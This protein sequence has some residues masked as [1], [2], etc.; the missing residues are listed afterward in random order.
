MTPRELAPESASIPVEV[1]LRALARVREGLVLGGL[2]VLIAALS[3]ATRHMGEYSDEMFHVPQIQGFCHA[4]FSLDSAITMLPGFHAVLALAGS[5]LHDCS[6]PTL[7]TLN[8]ALLVAVCFVALRILITLHSRVAIPRALALCFLPLLFPY[9]FVVYTDVLGLLVALWALLLWLQHRHVTAGLVASV[10]VL[11]RQTNIAM[12]LLFVALA[13]LERDRHLGLIAQARALLRTCWSS[14]LG[15]AAF[16]AFVLYNGGIAV[17]DQSRHAL[18]VQVGNLYFAL[19]LV[20]LTA[21]APGL[22]E[23]WR[24]RTALRSWLFA[25]TLVA[26]Y[27]VYRHYFK[28]EHEYNHQHHFLHNELLMRVARHKR[29]LNL[30]FAPIALGL[31]IMWT[32]SWSRAAFRVWL[33]LA[34]AMMVPES[35]IEPRYALLP[36]ALFM[37][38]RKDSSPSAERLGAALNAAMSVTLVLMMARADLLL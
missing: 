34:A 27:L 2:A 29:T 14:A 17:G 13:W 31:A 4:D 35:L 5:A 18:G 37:L 26:S 15:L 7:R 12:P 23:L 8:A 1:W 16:G 30:F 32:S 10:A 21:A 36:I 33:L 38:M 6:A 11:V 20:P 19:F 9:G 22:F 24:R 28:V 25:A 3:I